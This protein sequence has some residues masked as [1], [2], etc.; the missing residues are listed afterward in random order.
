M[1]MALECL[2]ARVPIRVNNWL[3]ANPVWL[4]RLEVPSCQAASRGKDEGGCVCLEWG[5]C[6]Y[7]TAR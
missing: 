5:L 4:F 6:Q 7:P 1:E 2:D 3:R